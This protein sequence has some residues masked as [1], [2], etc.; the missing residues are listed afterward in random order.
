MEDPRFRD[1][2]ST[3]RRAAPTPPEDGMRL[4]KALA[5][6]GLASRRDCERLVREG[7]IRVNG[8]VVRELPC[9]VRPGRDLLELD[10]DEVALERGGEPRAER[11]Y[12]ALNKPKGVISTADDPEGRTNVVAL[13]SRW[14]PRGERVYPVGRL[15]ADSTGLMLLTNDGDLAHRLAHPRF[16]VAKEYRVTTQGSLD[17]TAVAVLKKGMFLASPGSIA[18][19]HVAA[20]RGAE[21]GPRPTRAP[22]GGRRAALEDVRVL[23]RMAD[24]SRGDLSLLQVKLQEGQNR[25]IRRLLARVGVKVRRLE[26]VAIG[27]LKL[28]TLKPGMSRL[29]SP[30]EVAALRAA[31]GLSDRGSRGPRPQ[32][33]G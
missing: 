21:A 14:V 32:K 27:P 28:G 20:P 1:T 15:D 22:T 7:R 19:S 11:L 17:D 4:E 12:I 10:G 2:R 24:R 23:K 18:G 29:L 13:V 25:E 3:P 16:G 31:V 26:R 30:V 33:R 6:L 5:M 9:L 8:K